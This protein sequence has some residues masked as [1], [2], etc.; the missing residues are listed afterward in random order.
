MAKKAKKPK[1][2]PAP[3]CVHCEQPAVLVSG[4]EIYPHRDD[5]HD[6]AIWRCVPCRAHVGCH[7]GGNGTRPLGRPADLELRSARGK[8][9]ERM[10]DPLWKTADQSGGY[11]PE[12]GRAVF[13]IRAAARTRVYLFLSVKMG[14]SVDQCHIGEFSLQQC[15]EA[16]VALR[17]VT[18]PEIRAWCRRRKIAL[19][20]EKD[21]ADMAVLKHTALEECEGCRSGWHLD[22]AGKHLDTGML[23]EALE[24]R[25][26]MR[27]A[28]EHPAPAARQEGT[29]AA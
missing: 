10:V 27:F 20:L 22:D 19:V 11:R 17:G 25:D 21:G 9:H 8:L 7:K 5:L 6:L 1:V 13:I 23:C 18:Y 2:Y 28:E 26:A 15:R 12:N 3:L 4:A 14:L 29:D 24:I 16:W